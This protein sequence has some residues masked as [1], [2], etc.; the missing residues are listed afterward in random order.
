MTVVGYVLNPR[1]PGVPNQIR[2]IFSAPNIEFGYHT[3]N[4]QVVKREDSSQ[5]DIDKFILNDVESEEEIKNQLRRGQ[6]SEELA[7]IIINPFT[8]EEEVGFSK[9]LTRDQRSGETVASQLVVKKIE[10][11]YE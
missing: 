5:R 3:S 9:V 2:S 6:S 1:H 11:Q 8:G 7:S 10:T 4:T